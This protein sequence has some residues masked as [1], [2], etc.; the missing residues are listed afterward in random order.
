MTNKEQV[1]KDLKTLIG[2]QTR[3]LD[4]EINVPSFQKLSPTKQQLLTEQYA[5]MQNYRQILVLRLH[6]GIE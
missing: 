2:K 3:L 4:N 6:Y 1:R 5:V